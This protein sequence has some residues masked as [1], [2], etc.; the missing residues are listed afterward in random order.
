MPIRINNI[1]LSIDDEFEVLEKK[2]CKKLKVSK[3]NIN[4]IEIIKKST[5]ARK[6]N[7]IKFNY[8]VDVICDNEKKI[9]SKLH[10]KDVKIEEV[11]EIEQVVKGNEELKSRPVVIGFGP[12]GIFAALTLARQ[13][14]KPVVYERG[15][16]VD[17]R[18]KSVEKFWN[19]GKLNL[20]SNVQFGEGGAGTFS[21]G[22]LTT[23][24]KDLRCKFVLDEFVKAGAPEE[25]KYES[26]A[27]VG[28]DLLKGVVKNI[29]EEI[30]S[31]GGEVHF[32][33]K[34]EKIEF[35]NDKLKSIIVNGKKSNCE[36]LILAIGH[37]SRDTYEMLCEEGVSM[38]AKAFAI[39]VRI[40]HPQELINISQYGEN[41]NHSKLHAADYR[42]T[43][44]SERLKRGVYSF[45][46][47]PG[48]VVV[49]AAS[50]DG[51]L[52]SN[53]MSYHARNLENANSA[54]VVT[55][56]PEDFEGTSPLRGMEFQRHYESLA[57]KLGGGNYKAPVQL[58][59]D[60]MKDRPS[61][62]LGKVTP[63]YT[64][65]YEF[66]EL[67]EC[68][69]S[70]VIEALKEG[71]VNFD[72]KINGYGNDDAV[73]TGIETRT[74]APVRIHRNETLE[75]TNVSGLYPTGEGAGFAGGIISAAVDGIKVAEYIIKK[76]DLPRN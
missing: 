54:L 34:L 12:A 45:C 57:F 26:K 42:L 51:R 46:M 62:K 27:H 25:I 47:C 35:E 19:E 59:G 73:L 64:A 8:C 68:L 75:S 22:K 1:N 61:T 31:L 33:S 41:H 66:R 9:L 70:Y 48:G 24:I 60:F 74:S 49:A 65:G 36:A 53:G 15:E 67:K 52:V 17:N 50:E 30:K 14:Y 40:E 21:D 20:E 38:E 10:D 72:K 4:K 43:Y 69:P 18:T 13:G 58:V 6:K 76:F 7:D 11:K 28:T 3:D 5:D 29:R 71:I 32:N 39:G 63:S 37:S 23:R 56:S 55:V 2:I 44:Q 16:D